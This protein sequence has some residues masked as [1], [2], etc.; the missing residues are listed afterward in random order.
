MTLKNKM[1]KSYQKK[2]THLLRRYNKS[3]EADELWKGRFY[4]SQKSNRWYQFEDNSGGILYSHVRCY[5][6]K[7]GYYHDYMLSY[8]PWYS[9]IYWRIG[10]EI[11]N[12]FIV[13]QVGV[14]KEFPRPSR[15]SKSYIGMPKV[16]DFRS[17]DNWYLRINDW[18]GRNARCE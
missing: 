6:H 8:A 5:D 13:E 12:D 18:R 10:M 14:W 1:R 17:E 4:I 16:I 7:T 2:L 15:D 11:L 9:T 3:L